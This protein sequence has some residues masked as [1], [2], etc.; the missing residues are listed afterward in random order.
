[1]LRE[2]KGKIA[3]FT[4][5]N[6]QSGLGWAN[7]LSH[8]PEQAYCKKMCAQEARMITVSVAIPISFSLSSETSELTSLEL[9]LSGVVGIS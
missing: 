8:Y 7:S 3:V 6:E 5:E 1:M 9:G 4:V 2:G